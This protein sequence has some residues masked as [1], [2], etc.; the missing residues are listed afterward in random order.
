MSCVAMAFVRAVAG[1]APMARFRVV[2]KSSRRHVTSFRFTRLLSATSATD[3]PHVTAKPKVVV[4]TGANTGLGFISAREIAAKGHVVVLAVRD[5]RKG[6][7][8]VADIKDHLSVSSK[9]DDE[10][11]Q[12]HVMRLDLSDLQSIDQFV[13]E[14]KEKYSHC[15]V[16]MNNA[17][18]MAIPNRELTV[19]GIEKQM[20]TNHMGHFYLTERMMPLLFAAE[21]RPRV[22]N[23]SSIA[24]EWGQID[25]ENVNS[26]GFFGY[27]G[28]GW[29]TYGRTKVRAFPIH[30]TASLIGPITLTVYSYSLRET[31][32]FFL[33]VSA[34]ELIL[35]LRTPQ[36]LARLRR[37]RKPG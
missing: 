23:L 10:R 12:L 20:G 34:G 36:A 1:A 13:T 21:G 5:L 16:L 35:H 26:D 9:H 18:V 8:T 24:H 6:E 33:I 4:I 15:D 31:D 3:A 7:K 22:V 2:A 28:S 32:T 17:G 11:T 37:R 25:F 30:H 19:N 29:L 27:L 14:F